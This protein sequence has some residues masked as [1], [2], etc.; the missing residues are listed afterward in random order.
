MRR[1]KRG[2]RREEYSGKGSRRGE[3][4][5]HTRTAHTHKH[6]QT[7]THTHTHTQIISTRDQTQQSRNSP[8]SLVQSLTCEVKEFQILLPN[9]TAEFITETE[10]A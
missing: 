7:H 4:S 5:T 3:G 2:E 1:E 10:M 8:Q 6:A 9:S